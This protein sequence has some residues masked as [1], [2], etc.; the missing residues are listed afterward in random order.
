M[1][2]GYFSFPVHPKNKSLSR[3]F[4]EDKNAILLIDKLG[5]KEAFLGEHL[6][7]EH[8][9][10]S[11]SLLFIS[12]LIHKTKN[13]NLGTGTLNLPHHNPAQLASDIAMIDHI[14]AGRLI[15]GI[16]PGSLVSDMEAFNTIKKNR[17]EMFLESINHMI[18]IWKLKPPYNLKGKYWNIN[19]IK[20]FDKKLSIGT[21]M[22]T[23][24][25]PHPEIVCTSLS[26]NTKSIEALSKKGWNLLSS[27]FL[28]EESLKYHSKG[29]QKK[30]N[31]MKKNWRV[32]RKIFIN[33]NKRVTEDYVFSTKSPYFKTLVQIMNKLE[34]YGKIDVI[35]KNPEDKK[36]NIN[37]HKILKDLVIA[38]GA[39]E[40]A[41]KI[42]KLRENIG[43]FNTITYVGIDWKNPQ[44]AKN[45]LYLMS[46]KVIKILNKHT[47][48]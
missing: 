35:K 38:G 34:K 13:I 17:N 15:V 31:G 48:S 24:Q 22:N 43:N 1:Q 7:D 29:I 40:V 37:P 46:K 30:F 3:C 25:K 32:A 45:S 26:R 47:K 5:F 11:S 2:L 16:G 41:E 10:I 18:K 23:Y 42:L 27:N 4:E 12:S 8:E 44:L 19:T 6:T 36:E 28:Q 21:F 9:R 39:N 14:S 20:T 33:E